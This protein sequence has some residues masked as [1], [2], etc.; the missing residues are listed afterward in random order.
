MIRPRENFRPVAI[1]LET[2]REDDWRSSASCLGLD[3][4]DFFPEGKGKAIP[5]QV[6][7]ICRHCPVVQLCL[8]Y[9]LA[10]GIREGVYAGTSPLE[11]RGLTLGD[12]PPLLDWVCNECDGPIYDP[13]ARKCTP[14]RV[15]RADAR[16]RAR[17]QAEVRKAS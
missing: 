17:N 16:R 2:Q 6:R 4:D 7:R 15:R 12:T 10:S 1:H 8:D 5:Q 14:C 11:R 3:V 13:R 9:A